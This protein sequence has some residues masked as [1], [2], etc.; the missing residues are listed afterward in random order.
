VIALISQY[1]EDVMNSAVQHT[2]VMRNDMNYEYYV[3]NEFLVKIG[4]RKDEKIDIVNLIEGK[5][6]ESQSQWKGLT[7]TLKKIVVKELGIDRN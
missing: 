4:F 3:M 2:Y 1:Y 6:V 5:A 7:Q